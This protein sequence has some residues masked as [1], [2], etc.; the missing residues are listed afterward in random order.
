MLI[1]FAPVVATDAPDDNAVGGS[2]PS[3]TD[4]ILVGEANVP[5]TLTLIAPAVDSE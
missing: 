1:A 5:A 4:K 3:L 2:A